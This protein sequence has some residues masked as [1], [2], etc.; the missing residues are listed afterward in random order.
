[1]AEEE[2]DAPLF[3]LQRVYLKDL[4]VEIPHAPEVFLDNTQP[5]LSFEIDSIKSSDVFILTSLYE[6][7]PNVLL[8]SQAL[9]KFII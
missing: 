9:K 1:M 6:G 8:E 5:K 4:S 7:L 2:K 3:H